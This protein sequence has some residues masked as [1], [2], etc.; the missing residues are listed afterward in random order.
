MRSKF[1][2]DLNDKIDYTLSVRG[3]VLGNGEVSKDGAKK[4]A[5]H[6]LNN[7]TITGDEYLLAADY[8]GNGFIKLNDI[9]K[10][11]KEK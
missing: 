4:I 7:N 2:L 11:V 8:D 10:M 1:S 3:D 6:I 5:R 9:V